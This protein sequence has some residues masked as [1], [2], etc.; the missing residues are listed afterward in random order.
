[1]RQL[2]LITTILFLSSCQN[3]NV[4]V[5]FDFVDFTLFHQFRTTSVHIDSRKKI[6]ICTY[7]GKNPKKY[8]QGELS[9][10]T[11][12]KLDSLLKIIFN[13]QRDTSVGVPIPDGTAYR[14]VLKPKGDK[15]TITNWGDTCCRPVDELI[16][17]INNMVKEFK[18]PFTDTNFIFPSRDII[19]KEVRL[20]DTLMSDN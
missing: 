9:N 16:F 14:I 6:V 11:Q 13:S 3:T 15:I 7:W 20:T 19:P 2:L 8:Y 17:S 10:T 18:K 4:P 5:R 12:S 1:M